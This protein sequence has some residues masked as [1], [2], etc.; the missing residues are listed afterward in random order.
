MFGFL[1]RLRKEPGSTLF[2][3][4]QCVFIW[5]KP[6][7]EGCLQEAQLIVT[8][9]ASDLKDG[10]FSKS[11]IGLADC[12]QRYH[13]ILGIP[14]FPQAEVGRILK[15]R[16]VHIL[17]DTPFDSNTSIFSSNYSGSDGVAKLQKE[18]CDREGWSRVILVATYPHAWRARWIYERLGLKVIIPPD[19]PRMQFE[20]KFSQKRWRWPIT[21]Y[22]YEF[23]TRLFFL[24]KGLI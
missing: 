1:A 9:A 20:R 11:N 17:G 19:L 16:D 23:L 4:F 10:L 12:A 3:L 13:E 6:S 21:A 14:I 22:P 7:G 5:R 8:Q 15:Q 2:R 24:Y 18:L